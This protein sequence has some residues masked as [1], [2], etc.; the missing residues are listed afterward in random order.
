MSASQNQEQ[1]R[2]E[3]G[4]LVLDKF[5]HLERRELL[6]ELIGVTVVLAVWREYTYD[7]I[8]P[9]FSSSFEQAAALQAVS[10]QLDKEPDENQLVL[11]T[12][13]IEA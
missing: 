3:L 13:K 12:I 9:V 10:V 8:V 5:G 6:E 4:R 1:F 2:D 7:D 11:P